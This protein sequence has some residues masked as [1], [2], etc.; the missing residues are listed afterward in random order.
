MSGQLPDALETVAALL[1]RLPGVGQRSALRLAFHIL[2]RPAE[3]AAQLAGALTELHQAVGFCQVCG[4]LSADT[5]CEVC[6]DPQRDRRTICVVE[7]VVDLLAIEATGEFGGL[8]HVLHGVLSPLR[9][10]GP[11]QLHIASLVQ[12]AAEPGIEEVI[13]ATPISVEGEATAA[14]IRSLIRRS[15][16]VV[17]SRIA[18]GVPQGSDLEYIDQGTLGRALRARQPL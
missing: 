2:E 5:R 18:S 8:Y 16:H 6:T 11:N 1:G 7:G 17:V 15:P 4:H 14:Y 10:I 13:L 12:R 9:G 3:E